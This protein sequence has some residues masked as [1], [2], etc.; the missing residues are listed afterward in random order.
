MLPNPIE[1]TDTGTDF[2]PHLSPLI[3]L[4]TQTNPTPKLHFVEVNSYK[5]LG[6]ISVALKKSKNCVQV[7]LFP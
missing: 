5:L 6:S 3:L 1:F 4:K 7:T 2:L